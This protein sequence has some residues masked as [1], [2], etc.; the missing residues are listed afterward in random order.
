MK[1][2]IKTAMFAFAVVAA[3]F[4]SVK[5]YNAYKLSNMSDSDLILSE[6]T[7]ALS[8][9]EHRTNYVFVEMISVQDKTGGCYKVVPTG[10]QYTDNDGALH[11]QLGEKLVDHWVT[12]RDEPK[13]YDLDFPWQCQPKSCNEGTPKKHGHTPESWWT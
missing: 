1:K 9:S 3:G 13:P 7:E 6:N 12:C 8:Q 2:T 4:G 11:I 10:A 5:A